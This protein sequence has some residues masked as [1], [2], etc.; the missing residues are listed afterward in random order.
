MSFTATITNQVTTGAITLGSAPYI[1]RNI[2]LGSP[3]AMIA[4]N[5]APYQDGSSY[6]G[7]LFQ[8]TPLTIEGLISAA[9][10]T[11]VGSYRRAMEAVLNPKD[12][13]ALVDVVDNATSRSIMA[14]PEQISFP[15][16]QGRGPLSQ[17]FI[18]SMLAPNPLWYDPVVN[19]ETVIEGTPEDCGNDGDWDTPVTLVVEGPCKDPVIT[20]V[21]TSKSIKV[22]ITLAA[23]EL[24]TIVTA[25]GLKSITK[26]SGGVDT[27][28]MQYLDATS[29]DFFWLE[30]GINE[31]TIADDSVNVVE[32]TINWYNKYLGV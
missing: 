30:R 21:T 24:L 25:F 29:R 9:S 12:G 4:T 3:D 23:G 11:L 6:I 22:N 19:A 1:L 16:G 7:A 20:N 14:V 2:S 28:A 13:L 10:F 32:M 15:G 5:G 8:E 27:N 17:R 31:I 18:I 26:T